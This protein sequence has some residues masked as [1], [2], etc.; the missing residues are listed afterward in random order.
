VHAAEVTGQ[1]LPVDGS[2][3]GEVFRSGKPV[4]TE[5]FRHAIAG[6]TDVGQRSAVV[7]PLRAGDTVLG[8]IAVARNPDRP[9]FDNSYLELV[10]D[11]AGHAAIALRLAAAHARERD[12]SVLADRERI[13][14]DLHDHVIQRLFAT[15]MDLQ[16]SIARA[17]SPELIDRL[18]RSVDELQ[19]TIQEIRTTIFGLQHPSAP[20]GDFRQR[21]QELVAALTGERPIST[22]LQMVGPMTV[23]DVELADHAEAVIAEAISNAVRHSGASRLTIDM[24]AADQLVIDI[25]DNGRGIPPDN[26]RRS[27]LANIAHRAEQAG[28]TCEINTPADGGTHL[29]WTA[30][31]IDR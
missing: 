1:Q 30:P 2:T 11:F 15:G 7:M 13:A 6:F 3:S 24:S 8:V 16:G 28:G 14:H 23:V 27:G 18:T 12:L 10:S 20:T 22:T 29:R 17:R 26:Q 31:L 19:A 9:R 21:I 25:T 4:I 5:A